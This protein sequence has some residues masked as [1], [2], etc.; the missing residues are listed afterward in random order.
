MNINFVW[1][2]WPM[3]PKSVSRSTRIVALAA[4]MLIPAWGWAGE[5]ETQFMLQDSDGAELLTCDEH[6]SH[7]SGPLVEQNACYQRMRAAMKGVD[8]QLED[9][10]G[11][12]YVCPR[13]FW[14]AEAQ[15]PTWRQTM[16]DC[17]EGK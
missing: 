14:L 1:M 3:I 10:P 9:P 4:V 7:C 2:G 6:A 12:Y 8:Q 17:V 16:T 5:F 15:M 13:F 11:V